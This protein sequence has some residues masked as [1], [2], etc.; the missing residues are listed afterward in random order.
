MNRM[1][2]ALVLLLGSAWL[3]AAGPRELAAQP[4]PLG[5]EVV[6]LTND[7]PY[8]P[9]LAV[10]PGGDSL[11]VWDDDSG[12]RASIFYR[13]LAAGSTPADEWS[14][15]IESPEMYPQTKAVTATPKGFD[16][17]WQVPPFDKPTAFY[18]GHLNLQGEPEGKP[19]RLGGTGTG[20]VWQV[21]GNGFMAGWALPKK[22][23]I[24]ARRLTSSGQ[25]TGPEMRL[26]SRPVD[27]R[28]QSGPPCCGLAGSRPRA[29]RWALTSTST[30]CRWAR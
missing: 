13:F 15:S 19:V 28:V 18:R 30:R 5:P 10:Q 11:L 27:A 8:R 1:R 16:V 23:G 21:R 6:F 9:L 4:A 12:S 25:L 2:F 29:S 17:I 7:F 24:V 14:P 20:W 22:H 3:G 26:N